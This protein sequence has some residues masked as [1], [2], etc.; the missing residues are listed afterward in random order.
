MS[1]RYDLI[2]LGAGPG[3]YPAAI[4]GAQNGLGVACIDGWKNLDGTHAFGGTCLNAGCIPSK[5]LLESS[6][7][8]HRA[9][10]EFKAHGIGIGQAVI[11]VAAMQKRK[12]GIVKG[13]TGG[14][15]SLLKSSGAT[16]LPGHGRLLA[17]KVPGVNLVEYTAADGSKRTDVEMP[18]AIQRML[19]SRIDLEP[20]Q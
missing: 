1:D 20:V 7:L 19:G 10:H 17:S 6:E 9:Q 15:A 14:I 16:A 8:V 2:V 5:A 3:G 13:M 18:S 12:A 11:D 4:R